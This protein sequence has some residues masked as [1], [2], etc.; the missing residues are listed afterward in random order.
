MAKAGEE[1]ADRA[2]QAFA[3]ALIYL[4][5]ASEEEAQN[6]WQAVPPV[7]GVAATAWLTSSIRKVLNRS[8]MG[9]D[10][11][12]AFYRLDRALRTGE[13]IQTPDHPD[14][15]VTIGD[16]REE[17]YELVDSHVPAAPST[18]REHR[19]AI[20]AVKPSRPGG[21]KKV[22][23]AKI[24][25]LTREWIDAQEKD[26]QEEAETVLKAL[27]PSNL[28]RKIRQGEVKA[29]RPKAKK[30]PLK[31]VE[32]IRKKSHAEAGARV[33]AATGR[34]TKNGARGTLFEVGKADAKAIGYVRASRTGTPCGFCAMLISRGF[35]LYK[36]RKTAGDYE[37]DE[38]HDN[39]NC[40]AIP[41]FSKSHYE[42]SELFALNREYHKLWPTVTKGYGGN[43]ALNAWRR[44]ITRL[45]REHESQS[46]QAA[47][48][49]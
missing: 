21:E 4:G 49:A 39:C 38:F 7:R 36:S 5:L 31:A 37:G 25:G 20:E 17:F 16:L 45:N 10:L 14:T 6:D 28:D 3:L 42:T 48:A 24:S 27:G 33:A 47:D 2:A 44:Y 12:F 46:A 41:V 13:T 11:A 35:V 26:L 30:S 40:Y 22:K 9:R 1:E 8:R 18:P 19:A 23:A 43:D 32:E 15:S 34:M 29:Q